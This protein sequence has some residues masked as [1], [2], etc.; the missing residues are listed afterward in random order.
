MGA[1]KTF[2]TLFQAKHLNSFSAA[3]PRI[4]DLQK[5]RYAGI[6]AGGGDSICRRIS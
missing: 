2:E 6:A 5:K 4:Q 1:A 3:Y